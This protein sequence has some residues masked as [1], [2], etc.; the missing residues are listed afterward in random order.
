MIELS[1]ES[2]NDTLSHTEK[3]IMRSTNILIMAAGR[4]AGNCAS[5]ISA[6]N[7]HVLLVFPVGITFQDSTHVSF[8][9]RFTQV[10][11]FALDVQNGFVPGTVLTAPVL[12]PPTYVESLAN[13]A[14]PPD[15]VLLTLISHVH[16]P[17]PSMVTLSE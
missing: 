1:G 3:W 17:S 6:K 14:L 4:N 15:S 13:P 9:C 16:V 10:C 8:C 2:E 5:V 11:G 7:S 12:L